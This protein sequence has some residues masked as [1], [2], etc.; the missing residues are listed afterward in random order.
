MSF[1]LFATDTE[2]FLKSSVLEW[3]LQFLYFK[4]ILV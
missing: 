3:K 2:K 1:Q 4:W